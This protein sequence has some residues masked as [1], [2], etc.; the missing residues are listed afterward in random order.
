MKGNKLSALVPSQ[1]KAFDS[2]SFFAFV[3]K[4]QTRPI[5]ALSC[6]PSC[7]TPI[8]SIPPPVPH[9]FQTCTSLG[10][11]WESTCSLPWPFSKLVPAGKCSW[12]FCLKSFTPLFLWGS[13]DRCSCSSFLSSV[14]I[15]PA[16]AQSH[17]Y[18]WVKSV[19]PSC[20]LEEH[21]FTPL[22]LL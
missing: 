15:I 5:S 20:L 11:R 3:Y 22:L 13:S 7:V 1:K 10:H 16:K 21:H 2:A 6:A 4:K 9:P 8:Q 17:S 12:G 18:R 19:V 14:S